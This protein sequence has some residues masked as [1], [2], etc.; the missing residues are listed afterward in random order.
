MEAYAE[1]CDRPLIPK[2]MPSW[3]KFGDQTYRALKLHYKVNPAIVGGN[4]HRLNM[5]VY[6]YIVIRM[7]F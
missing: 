2:L 5:V 3:Y 1:V 7:H 6:G 4:I